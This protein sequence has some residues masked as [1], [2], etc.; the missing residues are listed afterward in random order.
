MNW[1]LLFRN[2][3]NLQLFEMRQYWFETLASLVA[4][5]GLFIA[6]FYGIKSF[7]FDG[8]ETQSLDGLVFGFL[9]WAFASGA[10][11]T[12]T[13]TIVEDTQKGYIEQLFINPKGFTSLLFVKAMVDLLSSLIFI[14]ILAYLTMW[15]T[16]NWIDINFPL[17]YLALLLA[18][19]S[20][21]GLGL[22]VSGFA[23]VFKRVDTIAQLLSLALMGL[24]ALDGLPFGPLSFLPFT[25]GVSLAKEWALNHSDMM[26]FDT[27]LV[28]ANSTFYLLIGSM[29][30]KFFERMAK[31][32]NLIGQ[33]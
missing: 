18:A 14:T 8:Q 22:I 24:V 7:G 17:F 10:Y 16:G 31:R 25:S 6:L 30:F 2:E 11:M 13:K 29:V 9:L 21:V 5:C 15:L 26:V 19:P 27:L 33:Y 23:L 3:I 1:W 32:K 4:I 12:V 20:L 28:L